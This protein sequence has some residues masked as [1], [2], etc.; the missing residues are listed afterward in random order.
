MSWLDDLWWR[1]EAGRAG[2]L[3]PALDAAEALFR[4]AAAVRG[5]LF[6]A[7]LARRATAPAA[8]VS[9]GNLAVGGAGKTPVA[10]AIAGRL[11]QRNRR[12]AV[13]SRGYGARRSG[14]RVV[15]DGRR[16]LLAEP[17]AGDEPL[18]VA[19]RL[20]GVAVLCGPSR[21]ELARRAV[22]EL[23]ADALVLDDGFQHR[24]L[25]RDLDVVVLDA[26][27]PVGNGRL[28]PRGPNREPWAALRRADLA[29]ITRADLVPPEALGALRRRAADATGGEPVVSR[30]AVTDVLDGP[31]RASLGTGALSGRRVALVC[32]LARPDG[33][34]RTV[35]GLGAQV[36]AEHVFRDHHRFT[37]LELE[38]LLARARAASCDAVVTS[39]KDAVR[40]GEPAVSDPIWRVVRIEAEVLS[41][42]AELE[43]GLEGALAR[44]DGR[45]SAA[46]R[47]A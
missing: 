15:S 3:L 13:L 39:E 24:A 9:V 1:G 23:G 7:G 38:R 41:G 4:G 35:A 17:D 40:L 14:P 20:P 31:L 29:W 21:A 22:T 46:G 47:R 42:G 34:R 27:C 16:V 37:P 45:R 43:R 8:V 36:V 33:F 19:R 2:P 44:G 32:A 10:I 6:D 11:Q 12:V 26:T 18:L 5:A 28:L 30:H 25:A